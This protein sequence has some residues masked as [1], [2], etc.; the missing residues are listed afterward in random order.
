MFL[1]MPYEDE[2]KQ[3]GQSAGP[4]QHT[5]PPSPRVDICASRASFGPA[6]CPHLCFLV[7]CNL[8]VALIANSRRINTNFASCMWF[9][10]VHCTR[11]NNVISVL[12]IDTFGTA[13]A[14]LVMEWWA[15]EDGEGPKVKSRW[16]RNRT[17]SSIQVLLCMLDMFIQVGDTHAHV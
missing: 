4:S 16:V 6:I 11:A 1:N 3:H 9:Y 7:S 2:N 5:L 15:H 17:R 13:P 12:V 8:I 10:F 14:Y